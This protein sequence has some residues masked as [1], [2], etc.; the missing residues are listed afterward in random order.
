LLYQLSFPK[1]IERFVNALQNKP[2]AEQKQV[3]IQ[4][5]D[6][7]TALQNLLIFE[8]YITSDVRPLSSAALT[9]TLF[10]M[11]RLTAPVSFAYAA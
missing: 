6:H 11:R 1:G 9:D 4:I 5:N 10:S 8:D 2:Y 3:K 7:E